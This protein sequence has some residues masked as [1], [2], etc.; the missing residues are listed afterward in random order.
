MPFRY[1]DHE[2]EIGVLSTGRTLEEA[3]ADG[4]RGMLEVMVDVATI[5]PDE[6]VPFECAAADLPS[7]FIAL[8]NELL[9]QMETRRLFFADVV[10]RAVDTDA[11]GHRLTGEARGERIDLEKHAVRTEVKAP[12][13][14]GLLV[15]RVGEEYWVR[16]V[17]DV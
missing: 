11:S 13:Y 4:A 2:A 15:E 10:I 14:Y 3:F 6:V 9:Y 17:L 8:L 7:L 12:T 5:S 16:C 1:L